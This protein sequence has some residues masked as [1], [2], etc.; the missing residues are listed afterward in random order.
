M[1]L[2]DK[3]EV[4]FFGAK[5]SVLYIKAISNIITLHLWNQNSNIKPINIGSKFLKL[6]IEAE[7]TRILQ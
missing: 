3:W 4:M 7:T 2:G 5:I 1:D 6:N